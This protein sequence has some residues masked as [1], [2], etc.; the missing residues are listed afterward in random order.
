LKQY[1]Q[2]VGIEARSSTDAHR[3]VLRNE[4]EI[5]QILSIHQQKSSLRTFAASLITFNIKSSLKQKDTGYAS[6]M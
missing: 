5:K 1:N 3:K 2:K 6:L 4:T